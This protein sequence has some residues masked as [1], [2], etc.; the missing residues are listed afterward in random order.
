MSRA[1]S[2]H[3]VLGQNRRAMELTENAELQGIRAGAILGGASAAFNEIRKAGAKPTRQL[4]QNLGEGVL[5][6]AGLGSV[7]A[8]LFAPALL[9]VLH[10][11]KQK[12]G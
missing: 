10:K 2:L 12:Q 3:T 6:G 9:R 11:S 7:G 4:V 8:I 5:K 1:G